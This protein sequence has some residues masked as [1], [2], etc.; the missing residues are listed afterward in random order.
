ME[1]T[2]PPSYFLGVKPD[3]TISVRVNLLDSIGDVI[4]DVLL[5]LDWDGWSWDDLYLGEE[6]RISVDPITGEMWAIKF[7]YSSVVLVHNGYKRSSL[8]IRYVN[9]PAWV[10]PSPKAWKNRVLLTPEKE[11]KRKNESKST[12]P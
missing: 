11:Q 5:D 7:G 2:D 9:S 12:A 3:E 1:W 6:L 4:G 8:S 10:R